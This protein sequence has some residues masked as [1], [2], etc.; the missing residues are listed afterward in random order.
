MYIDPFLA[1]ILVTLSTLTVALLTGIVIIALKNR[2]HK[3]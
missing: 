1:G 3:E 2:N